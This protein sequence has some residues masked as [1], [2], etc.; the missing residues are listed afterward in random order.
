MNA[1]GL[2]TEVLP[3]LV[4]SILLHILTFVLVDWLKPDCGDAQ[5]QLGEEC[6]DGNLT[7]KDGCS[8]KCEI[9]PVC[10]NAKIEGDPDGEREECDDGNTRDGDG[11]NAKCELEIEIR[12]ILP[13]PPPEPEPEEPPPPEPEPEEPPPPPEEPPP[14][15][16]KKP[17]KEKE[18][19]PPPDAPPPPPAIELPMDQVITG[20]GSGV[21]VISGTMSR[22]GEAG[23]SREGKEGGKKGGEGKQLGTKT[24]KPVEVAGPGWEPKGE[25]Y[26]A[27]WPS[28]RKKVEIECPAVIEL[29]IAGT[30]VLKVQVRKD[31]T[32]RSVKVAKRMGH[33]CDEIAVKALK[34]TKFKPAIATD[35]KAV[36]FEIQRYEYEFRAP[37]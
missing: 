33:G 8:P 34:Q 1:R 6:D 15:V 22:A 19:P 21:S 32:V 23:G 24:T 12:E 7:S 31:G 35:G 29:G 14:P 18:P 36:D 11:C 3:P 30:V 5:V 9:E 25:L 16:K 17:P 28:P 13:P 2:A 20:G 26:I 37:R 27:N 10:G 4:V